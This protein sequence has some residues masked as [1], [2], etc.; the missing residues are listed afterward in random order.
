M[1]RINYRNHSQRTSNK[2]R[3]MLTIVFMAYSFCYIF[4]LQSDMLAY[5][6]HVLSEGHTTY[7]RL[8]GS[9]IVV[10]LVFIIHA[11]VSAITRLPEKLYA[12][13]FL[14]SAFTTFGAAFFSLFIS[15]PPL[16]CSFSP[17]PRD[18]NSRRPSKRAPCFLP[19]SPR[20][21]DTGQRT[22]RQISGSQGNAV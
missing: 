6:Q 8:V 20:P 2:V 19:G 15:G 18:K 4:I 17:G 9:L 21:S 22:S 10:F 12:F 5:L 7:N 1:F 13:T 3:A 16:V 11:A 14:P